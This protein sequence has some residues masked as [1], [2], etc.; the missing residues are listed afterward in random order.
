MT[1][2][3]LAI[4]SVLALALVLYAQGDKSV[5]LKGYLIDNMCANAHK[6]DAKFADMV[7][8]HK[9]SCGL[10][11]NCAGSGFAVLTDEGKLYKLDE[12]GS[13]T[14]EDL[15]RNTETKMG[16]AVAVEGTIDGETLKVSKLTELTKTE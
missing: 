1:R 4:V 9:T 14:A 10:M 2:R 3:L 5:K 16:V 11:P 12:A 7:K 13:K 15:L 8:G 6:S